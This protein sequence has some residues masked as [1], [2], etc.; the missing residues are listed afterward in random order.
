MFQ[1]V[2]YCFL[3]SSHFFL[4]IQ[5]LF[6]RTGLVTALQADEGYFSIE[7]QG[8]RRPY[9]RTHTGAGWQPRQAISDPECLTEATT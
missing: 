7:L 6:Q 9:S 2:M 3:G 8:A 1:T 5:D 4:I